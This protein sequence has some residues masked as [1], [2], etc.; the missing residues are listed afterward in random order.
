MK[1]EL[2]EQ[3]INVVLAGLGKLPL[4]QSINTFAEVQRQV[5]ENN[6][7]SQQEATQEAEE[8][9]E[10]SVAFIGDKS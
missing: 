6:K 7:K 2:S 5:A 3:H 9:S 1:I 10:S 8:E 4:E